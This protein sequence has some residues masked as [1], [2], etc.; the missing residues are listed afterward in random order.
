MED[1][2]VDIRLAA[3]VPKTVKLK[4]K[5]LSSDSWAL[6]VTLELIDV[7]NLIKKKRNSNAVLKIARTYNMVLHALVNLHSPLI[8]DS[9]LPSLLSQQHF[10]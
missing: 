10:A 2:F 1:E 9:N 8:E 6:G 3:S 5:P 4:L 7:N